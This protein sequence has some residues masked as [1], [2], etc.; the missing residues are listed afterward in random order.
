[1][2]AHESLDDLVEFGDALGEVLHVLAV[3]LK[4]FVWILVRRSEVDAW[5]WGERRC[6]GGVEKEAELVKYFFNERA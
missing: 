1:M 5:N 4:C 3:I 6:L 2:S